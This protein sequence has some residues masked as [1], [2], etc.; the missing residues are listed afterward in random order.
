[1]MTECC[2]YLFTLVQI[3]LRPFILSSRRHRL[4]G[5]EPELV[6]VVPAVLVHLL[7]Q[8]KLLV[9]SD[10]EMDQLGYFVN[11]HTF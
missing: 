6:S 10:G 11:A 9:A 4:C 3:F 2:I 8:K 7:L 1:M 5:R